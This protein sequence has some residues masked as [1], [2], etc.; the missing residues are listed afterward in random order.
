MSTPAIDG[1]KEIFNLLL[2]E[3]D[4]ADSFLFK[5]MV[6]Q[7]NQQNFGKESLKLHE[8]SEVESALDFIGREGCDVFLL[9]LSLPGTRGME[10]VKLFQQYVARIPALILTGLDDTALAMSAIRAGFQDYLVK[11]EFN[12][13]SLW[14][15]IQHAVERH[16]LLKSVRELAFIDELTKLLNRRG[17]YHHLDKQ[18]SLVKRQ[19][20]NLSLVYIDL[21][22]FKEI[23]DEFG[24]NEGDKVLIDV[25]RLLSDI[26]R[27]SDIIA[28][29]GGD[30]FAVLLTNS[31][32]KDAHIAQE[33]LLRGIDEFDR[34][35]TKDYH[36]SISVGIAHCDPSEFLSANE[37]VARADAE[38]Y[39]NKAKK[40][41]AR[42]Y[43]PAS[44]EKNMK[45]GQISQVVVDTEKN[46]LI[47]KLTGAIRKEEMDKIY[48][49]LI[50]CVRRVEPGFD[51]LMDYTECTLAHISSLP[52]FQEMM[53]FLLGRHVEK[54]V[55]VIGNSR[56]IYN[57]LS[58]IAENIKGFAPVYVSTLIEAEK[59]FSAE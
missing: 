16:T 3:D 36:I 9:D 5:Q 53:E 51:V 32:K 39:R 11:G 27:D 48:L 44:N 42:E 28:R 43:I 26:F 33:R 4:P 56:L 18:I 59:I 45:S 41:T 15:S 25:A 19:K 22:R 47:I 31:L 13:H 37:L 49:D 57:Q 8:A 23:N 38:M 24:H 1:E 12:H 54:V 2:I 58:K 50:D 40:R 29:L 10:T 17:F 14:R 35:N 6:E 20:G 34:R 52:T 7:I 55:G 21:D 30:E 46:R